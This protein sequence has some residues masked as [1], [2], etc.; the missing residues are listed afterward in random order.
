MVET[1][2]PPS[3]AELHFRNKEPVKFY[4]NGRINIRHP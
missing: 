4:K 1:A 3:R 2:P